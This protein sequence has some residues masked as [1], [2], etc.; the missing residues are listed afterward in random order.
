[1]SA[2]MKIGALAA[3]VALGAV[4]ASHSPFAGNSYGAQKVVYHVNED[5]GPELKRYKAALGNIR[6]HMNAVGDGNIDVKVVMH[7]D[8]VMLLRE[9]QK[10]EALRAA[11]D[12]LRARGVDFELCNNTLAGRNL[13]LEADFHDVDASVVPSGV[14]ELS[15]L[16]QM[17]YT[18]IKP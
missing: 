6:N 12:G 10:D 1:M 7:S 3:A 5:G 11:L 18:Y 8:G 14:A 2:M 16:Q 15:R 17:G 13:D 4:L 9:A